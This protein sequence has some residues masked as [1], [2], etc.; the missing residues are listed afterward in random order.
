MKSETK[1]L[2]EKGDFG[3]VMKE[4]KEAESVGMVGVFLQLPVMEKLREKTVLILLL[5]LRI[6]AM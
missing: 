6:F 3:W 5:H 1:Q 2:Q 4:T